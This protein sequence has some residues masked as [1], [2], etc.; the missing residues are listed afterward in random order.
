MVFT[1]DDKHKVLKTVFGH[2]S[3][4]SFQEDAVDAILAK[5]DLMVVLPTGGGKSLC[6]QLPT[7]L[8]DGNRGRFVFFFSGAA[9]PASRR[10]TPIAN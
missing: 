8:M 5:K 4:R 9:R 1:A 6:Y 10:T 3:F 2:S 7:L